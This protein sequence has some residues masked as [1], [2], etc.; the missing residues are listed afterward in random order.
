MQRFFFFAKIHNATVT[1]T[2]LRYEGS[3]GIDKKILAACGI[4]KHEKVQVLNLSNGMRFE[5]YVIEEKTGS[6]IVCL[7]GPA[8]HLGK[9][10][11]K[12]FIIAYCQLDEKEIKKHRPR[13]VVLDAHNRIIKKKSYH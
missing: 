1:N 10:N 3:I 12:V 13:V 11:D 2:N 7:Y 8:A 6:G 9:A 5:T 4:L